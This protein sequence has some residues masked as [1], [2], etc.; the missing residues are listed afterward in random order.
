LQSVASPP[1]GGNGESCLWAEA[2]KL[3]RQGVPVFPCSEDK[4]PLVAGGFK[5]ASSD[6]EIV[7]RWWTDWPD[8]LI[9]VPTGVKFDVLDVDNGRHADAET[10]LR[11]NQHRLPL[12]RTHITRSNGRHLLFAP[13]PGLRCG[14]SRLGPHV[15]IRAAGGYAVMWPAH[16]LEVLHAKVLAPVPEWMLEALK[17]APAV[18]V[19]APIVTSPAFARRKLNGLIRKFAGARVGERN[20]VGFWCTCRFAEMVRSGELGRN[21]AIAITIEVAGRT[22]L[23]RPEAQA[24]I[25]SAFRTIGV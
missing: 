23:T 1:A 22:G 7:H 8:A 17:P 16:G 15:D 4:R 25:K 9:A 19:S 12:T 18:H 14:T 3:A 6:P 21:D 5:S 10:W 20:T 13:T 11:E 2:L 24:L